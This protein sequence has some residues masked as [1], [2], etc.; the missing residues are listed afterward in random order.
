MLCPLIPLAW[1]G[2]IIR[3]QDFVAIDLGLESSYW[4]SALF[5]ASRI[6]QQINFGIAIQALWG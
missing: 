3:S 6:F 2:S 4:K 5:I 1:I